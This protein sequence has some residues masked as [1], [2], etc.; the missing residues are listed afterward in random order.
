MTSA[1]VRAQ[2]A[3]ATPLVAMR[4]ISKSFA[5]NEVLHKVDFDIHAGRI[6][7]LVGHNG[8][9]KSTLMKS[10]AGLYSDYTGEVELS[11]TPVRLA[12]PAASLAAGVAVIY[13]EFALI[14][15]FTVDANLALGR[16]EHSRL[17]VLRKRAMRRQAA[18]LLADLGFDLPSDVP[19]GRL[20]VAHQQLTEIAKALGRQAKVLV[21][22]EPTA[23]LAP[24]ERQTLFAVTRKL[25]ARGVGVVYISHF[26]EEV[27]QIS[28]TVT[29][30]R[31][32]LVIA[33]EPTQ[34]FTLAELSQA[35]AG[36]AAADPARP[37]VGP[38]A[39]SDASVRPAAGARAD[40]DASVRPEAGARAASD[41]RGASDVL[42]AAGAR[43]DSEARADSD[44]RALVELDG[45]AALGRPKSTLS[46]Q[47]GE[48]VGLA[49]LVG[50]G[51][52]SL[53]EAVCG[54]RPHQGTLRIDGR[55]RGFA[56]PAQAAEAGVLLVPEDR[57]NRGLVLTSPVSENITLTTMRK[58][59]RAGFVRADKQRQTVGAA[60]GRF[61][62]R[63][64]DSG[65]ALARSLSGGNQQKVLI[66]RVAVARP[67]VLILDQ[68]TAGVDIGA[69]AEIYRHIRELAA[70]GVA[71]VVVS[72]EL[73]ELLTLCSR[74][75]VVRGGHVVDEFPAADLDPGELLERISLS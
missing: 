55:P 47:A 64:A 66:A 3:T 11:G 40:S 67:K 34:N 2:P 31:D 56:S 41:A 59:C 63:G 30:L 60:I 18:E 24:A 15:A 20:S 19:V 21:M 10:L 73:E 16:E 1:E 7:A 52:T 27:L 54:A 9:G 8:A 25:A 28:D 14:P 75:A 12:S 32:G 51:R 13:Q 65:R 45:F 6:H 49:G 74:I 4:G 71:C 70:E 48:I 57:K 37:S 62:I 23:R 50:S 33:D 69:K 43:A 35:I 61:N 29:V 5:G 68:P 26:L 17:G 58:L 46:V 39:G 72:D 53:V 22:D 44:A 42:A 36:D 38:R